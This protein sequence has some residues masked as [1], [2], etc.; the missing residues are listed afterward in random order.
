M[1]R[2]NKKQKKIIFFMKIDATWRI[3]TAGC[4]SVV[5]DAL[6]AGF[7]LGAR[8]MLWHRKA[9]K[10]P[11]LWTLLESVVWLTAIAPNEA[12]VRGRVD[13]ALYGSSRRLR[14]CLGWLLNGAADVVKVSKHFQRLYKLYC[15]SLRN[16]DFHLPLNPPSNTQTQAAVY[17]FRLGETQIHDK[18][19]VTCLRE[20]KKIPDDF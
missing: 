14:R 15:S 18:P 10:H 11:I 20:K 7:A 13:A 12:G 1:A 9:V 4:L 6:F 3:I 2:C 17:I 5:S 16:P 8:P 19:N